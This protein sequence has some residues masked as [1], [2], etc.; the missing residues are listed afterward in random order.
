MRTAK[1]KPSSNVLEFLERWQWYHALPAALRTLTLETATAKTAVA[2]D[3]IARA[4]EPST[5]WHGLI[6]GVL[7]MYVVS[8]EQELPVS[9]HEL[10]LISGLPRQRVN[11]AIPLFN[12]RGIV[13]SEPR[14]GLMKVHVP[15]VGG[16]RLLRDPSG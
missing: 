9:Q 7:Q 16:F 6:R 4:G 12:R 1:Q 3:Y 11:V 14:K 5:H 10:A 15:T 13:R 8:P 2:G